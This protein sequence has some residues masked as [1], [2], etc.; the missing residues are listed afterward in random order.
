MISSGHNGRNNGDDN[1]KNNSGYSN[2]GCDSQKDI[3]VVYL[4]SF[5]FLQ[6]ITHLRTEIKQKEELLSKL[7]EKVT[8]WS[9]VNDELQRKQKAETNISNG[10]IHMTN[11]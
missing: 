1:G 11:S 10:V 2:N 9:K 3:I 8:N 5:S 4:I 6:E 7:S